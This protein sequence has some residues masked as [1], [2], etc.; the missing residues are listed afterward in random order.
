MFLGYSSHSKAYRLVSLDDMTKLERS[1]NVIF[2]EAK[3]VS[4]SILAS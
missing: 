4:K 3:M 1:R 2:D